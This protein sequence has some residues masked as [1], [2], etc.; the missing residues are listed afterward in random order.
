VPGVQG[1]LAV[2]GVRPAQ[3]EGRLVRDVPQPGCRRSKKA[4]RENALM[5]AS[6]E[7]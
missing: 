4:A 1:L 3:S 2:P 7:N 5:H 6:R